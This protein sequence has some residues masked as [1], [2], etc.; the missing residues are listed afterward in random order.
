MPVQKFRDFAEPER[1]MACDPNDP[2][3]PQRIRRLWKFARRLTSPAPFPRGVHKYR[4][5]ED[6][7][8]ARHQWEGEHVRRLAQERKRK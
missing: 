7:N 4:S 2:R 8:A 3:L 5:L 1:A 6:A